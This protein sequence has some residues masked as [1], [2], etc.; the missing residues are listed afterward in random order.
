MVRVDED[1]R[2]AAGLEREVHRVRAAPV[3]EGRVREAGSRRHSVEGERPERGGTRAGAGGRVGPAFGAGHDLLAFG[4]LR[5]SFHFPYT[6]TTMNV[7]G[8]P[9]TF[10][11]QRL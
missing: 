10:S 9:P 8:V 2:P 7:N 4:N 11:P 1:D 3:H 5:Q 6:Y